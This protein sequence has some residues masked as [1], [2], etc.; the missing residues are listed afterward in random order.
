MN[1]IVNAS[2]TSA[3]RTSGGGI[4]AQLQEVLGI[5]DTKKLTLILALAAMM[6]VLVVTYMWMDRATYRVVFP[7][8]TDAD[9]GAVVSALQGAAI[10]HQIDRVSG[11]VQ[12]PMDRVHEARFLLAGQ[13]LPRGSGSGFEFLG[14]QSQMGSSEFT[15]TAR[16]RHALENELARSIASI[17]SVQSARVHLAI[18]QRTAFVRDRVPPSASVVLSLFPGRAMETGQVGAI[19][20]MV[21]TAVAGM[22]VERVSIIDQMGRVLNRPGEKG[23]AASSHQLA[24]TRELETTY[25]QRIEQLLMPLVGIGRVR[26]EA[27]V[28]VDFTEVD[29]TEERFDRTPALRSEQFTRAPEGQRGEVP[30]VAEGVVG[31][32]GDEAN[33][34]AGQ[35]VDEN[36]NPGADVGD[37][38]LNFVRNYE[39]DKSISHTRA[40]VG[41]ITR[42]SVAVVVDYQNGVNESGE[43]ER[44]PRSEEEIERLTQL[45][46]D[47]IGFDVDRGDSVSV[48]SVAFQSEPVIPTEWWEEGWVLASG[49]LLVA[50][51]LGLLV[52]FVVIRPLMK[53]LISDST[54]ANAGAAAGQRALGGGAGQPGEGIDYQ[55]DVALAQRLAASDPRLAAQVLKKW[56]DDS[57]GR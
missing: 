56:I 16:Y 45:I 54:P 43:A 37:R 39:L 30:E 2:N 38:D 55:S 51:I 31:A 19:A 4:A 49:K 23:S 7:N 57:N 8:L 14:E 27:S 42:L 3:S 6:A 24:Y 21:S 25:V 22:T 13:G 15:T 41:R 18:P 32:Q 28:N 5:V 48:V 46:K 36:A 9:A 35:G 20:H 12:V 40:Q 17:G 33:A 47:A 29:R 53:A 11:N 52:L 10:P 1:A 50:T 44:Q 34:D 26:A